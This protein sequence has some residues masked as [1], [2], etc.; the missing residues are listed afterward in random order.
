ML[1]QN[2]KHAP[3]SKRNSVNSHEVLKL[4][5]SVERITDADI[6]SAKLLKMFEQLVLQCQLVGSE[7]GVVTM[8]YDIEPGMFT[9]SITLAVRRIPNE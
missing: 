7:S 2:L 4:L 8:D 3:I 6:N 9:P 1:L 5:S